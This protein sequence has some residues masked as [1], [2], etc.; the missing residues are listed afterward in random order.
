MTVPSAPAGPPEPSRPG[1]EDGRAS[2]SA[3][4]IV[5]EAEGLRRTFDGLTAV[6]GVDVRIASGEAYGL[7]GPNGAGKTT[8]ISMLCGLLEPDGGT[9]RVA[10]HD[11][12]RE[13]AAAKS[14]IGYV[15]QE[16]ALYP[17]LTARENLAFF[18]RLYGL[19]GRALADR[20]DAVL[21]VVGLAHRADDRV[22]TYSGGMKRR[23]NIGAG[24]LHEPRLVVL[25]EPTVGVDPQSRHA[26]LESVAALSAAGTAI[27]YTSHYMEE[28]ERLCERVG[29]IDHGRMIAEGTRRD[30]LA[31]L[32][33][34]DRVDLVVEGEAERV[35]EACREIT[36]VVDAA[37]ADREVTLLVRHGRARLAEVV[38]TIASAGA[39]LTSVELVEPDLEAVFLALTGRALRDDG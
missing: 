17:D 11:L 31:E 7:L 12:A 5:L 3:T 15:P 10:G 32:G 13:P 35:A 6:D 19:R 26:I 4:G 27:L 8:T 1:G 33:E 25:D 36:G 30:L 21:E 20:I 18:G 37:V 28:V 24:L 29:I 16:I 38:A 14:A 9:V 23:V 2:T 39:T 22:G 34:A